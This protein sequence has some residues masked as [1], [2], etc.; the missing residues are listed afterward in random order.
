MRRRRVLALSTGVAGLL[1]MAALAACLVGPVALA[2]R[3]LPQVLTGVSGWRMP[4][5][6]ASEG[7]PFRLTRLVQLPG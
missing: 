6:R 7:E 5:E 3:T 1:T 4:Q 2:P